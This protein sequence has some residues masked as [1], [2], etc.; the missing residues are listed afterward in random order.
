MRL[1]VC[2]IGQCSK[3]IGKSHYRNS[4]RK[5]QSKYFVWVCFRGYTK[6]GTAV[7]SSFFAEKGGFEP[8]VQLPVRQFSKLLV[9]A[10][11]PPLQCFVLNCFSECKVTLFSQ[12]RKIFPHFSSNSSIFLHKKAKSTQEH[13]FVY[14][15][16]HG[17]FIYRQ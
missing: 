3:I 4:V 10:T 6:K 9:S 12:T 15:L 5:Q 2:Q 14:D 1:M 11:H 7:C 8:P 16:I 17:S 13:I